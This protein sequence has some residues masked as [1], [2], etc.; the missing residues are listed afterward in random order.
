MPAQ[1][2]RGLVQ[3]QDLVLPEE[4]LITLFGDERQ[5]FAE[6]ELLGKRQIERHQ[7]FRGFGA[8]FFGMALDCLPD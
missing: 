3:A 8:A 1:T 5:R 6:R 4:P 7:H 2:V